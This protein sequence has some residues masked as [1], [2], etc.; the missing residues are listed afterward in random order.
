VKK[1]KH[2]VIDGSGVHIDVSGFNHDREEML[3]ARI[4]AL[5]DEVA[6]ARKDRDEA[7]HKA[8]VI[9]ENADQMYDEILVLKK[10]LGEEDR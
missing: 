9:A 2:I 1:L 4:W 5:E 3:S 10:R 6:R 7:L 8:Q